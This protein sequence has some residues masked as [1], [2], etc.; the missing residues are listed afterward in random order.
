[1][2]TAGSHPDR[3]TTEAA[4]AALCSVSPVPASSGKTFRHRLSR[5]G[6]HGANNA[7]HCIALVRMSTANLVPAPT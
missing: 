5:G 1:M 6:D 3:L 2:I 7:L 4:L